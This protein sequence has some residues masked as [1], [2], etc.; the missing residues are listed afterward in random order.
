M[1]IV[2]L[3]HDF[4][5]MNK[6]TSTPRNKKIYSEDGEKRDALGNYDWVAVMEYTTKDPSERFIFGN[7]EATSVYMTNT[8]IQLTLE[9]QVAISHYKG[10]QGWDSSKENILEI[11]KAYPLAMYLYMSDLKDVINE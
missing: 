1:I 2:A 5:R 8:F 3:F 11:Y 4:S 10:G 6:Y 7:E 9:E